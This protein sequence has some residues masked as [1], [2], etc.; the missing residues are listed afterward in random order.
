[1][2]LMSSA[3]GNDWKQQ[4]SDLLEGLGSDDRR[5]VTKAVATNVLE[6]WKPSRA[7]IEILIAGVCGDLTE[8]EYHAKVLA[9]V[10]EGRQGLPS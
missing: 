6:G 8:E 2:A 3:G 4:C 10:A 1:M 9:N 7:E 5:V